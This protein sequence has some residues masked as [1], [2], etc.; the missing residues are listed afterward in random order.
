[1][2]FF[3][4]S[5]SCIWT[6]RNT[7]SCLRFD[8]E[9]FRLKRQNRTSQQ[10]DSKHLFLFFDVI[11]QSISVWDLV[12]LLQDGEHVSVFVDNASSSSLSVLQDTLFSGI[13]LGVWAQTPTDYIRQQS[14]TVEGHLTSSS[15]VWILK[16]H[17]AEVDRTFGSKLVS[18]IKTWGL[19]Q[20]NRSRPHGHNSDLVQ[21]SHIWGARDKLSHLHHIDSLPVS[22]FT[23]HQGHNFHYF[24]FTGSETAHLVFVQIHFCWQS[25]KRFVLQPEKKKSTHPW[26]P[27]QT[28]VH[29]LFK[30]QIFYIHVDNSIGVK[31]VKCF[32]SLMKTSLSSV[33]PFLRLPVAAAP[34]SASALGWPDVGP[35][36]TRCDLC[37]SIMTG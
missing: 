21:R 35:F 9:S 19:Q 36:R 24:S 6:N 28:E 37:V 5:I 34:L 1:M 31:T 16:P 29:L 25:L 13:L 3:S 33:F 20:R 30:W 7:L 8:T 32:L 12:L 14:G 10:V 2:E 11:K 22:S 27:R 26:T 18:D 15:F 4:Q 17:R 23:K